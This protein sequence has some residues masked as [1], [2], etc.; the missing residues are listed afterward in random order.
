MQT[1]LFALMHITPAHKQEMLEI[2]NLEKNKK[3]N[4]ND[5][6]KNKMKKI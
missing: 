3:I 2:L 1:S 5:G 6:N 4:N